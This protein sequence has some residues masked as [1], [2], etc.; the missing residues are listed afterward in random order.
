M[1]APDAQSDDFA[2][3]LRVATLRIAYGLRA[4]AAAHG[5]TPSRLAALVILSKNGPM[6]AGDFA[7]RM[8]ITAPSASRLVDVL[9]DKGF[10][11]RGP[12]PSDQRA[13]LLSLTDKGAA[14][15]GDVRHEARGQLVIRLEALPDDLRTQL[16]PAIPA[17]EALADAFITADETARALHTQPSESA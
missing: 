4:R 14:A 5:L 11:A 17:L 10:A 6:R 15:M 7:R 12:D 9:V 8:G 13:Y 3:R 1:S 16:I 2:E